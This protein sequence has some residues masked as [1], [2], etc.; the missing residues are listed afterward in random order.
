[1]LLLWI[2]TF[3]F[4]AHADSNAIS[5]YEKNRQ[6][7]IHKEEQNRNVLSELYK[8]Q[9]NIK[10]INSD[11]NKLL[12]K[13]ESI[14]RHI[15]KL[16]PLVQSA[17]QKISTQKI[18]IQKRLLYLVKFQDMS[19]LKVFFSSQ[20]PTELDRNLRILK[21]LTERDYTLLKTYFKNVN[22]LKIK[23]A[24]LV[25]KRESLLKLEKEISDKEIELKS[26]SEKKNE[27]LADIDSQKNKLLAK[28]KDIRRKKSQYSE[29]ITK[30]DLQKEEFLSTIF[31][32][33]FFERKG[34]LNAPVDGMIVQKYGYFSHPKYKT[35]IRNKGLFIG[36]HAFA[37]TKAIAKGKVVHLENSR[38]SGYTMVIDH[39][40]HYYS[41]YSYMN[42]PTVKLNDEVQE[43]QVLA[44]AVQTH[45][46]FGEGLYFEMRHFSEPI[47]PVAWFDPNYSKVATRRVR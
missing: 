12:V 5:N 25:T 37:E 31:E 20:S 4:H 26:G 24:E 3:S 2:L 11:K 44:H 18:D 32:P 21:N 43:G 30:D 14:E 27:M 33:L 29:D 17:E 8:T 47:D 38:E 15:E 34:K 1:M 36:T 9:Q 46:F 6:D 10:K 28:L 35:Q 42:E 41:V 19:V 45:P 39:S 23:Q 7:Y 16:N 40:D 22:T 13:K